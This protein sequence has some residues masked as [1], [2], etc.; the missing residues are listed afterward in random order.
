MSHDNQDTTAI[1]ATPDTVVAETTTV[2]TNGVVRAIAAPAGETT[3]VVAGEPTSANNSE[4][5]AVVS[6]EPPAEPVAEVTPAPAAE[7]AKGP[8]PNIEDVDT[9]TVTKVVRHG[10]G[11]REA[12]K[13][14]GTIRGH[15]AEIHVKDL[16]TDIATIK[17]GDTVQAEVISFE[18]GENHDVTIACSEKLAVARA[19]L[20]ASRGKPLDAV[21]RK[22]V[23]EHNGKPD[24]HLFVTLPGGQGARVFVG[25]LK[26][27]SREERDARLKTFKK[28]DPIKVTLDSFKRHPKFPVL[29]V[30]CKEFN[31]ERMTPRPQANAQ[32]KPAHRQSN[33]R[34]PL[35]GN[36]SGNVDGEK[37]RAIAEAKRAERRQR[38]QQVRNSMK[39]SGGKGGKGK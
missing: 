28:G 19:T 3:P 36:P 16:V 12:F 2:E 9:F 15:K 20:E 34:S 22:D 31:P 37:K 32:P 11:K 17:D 5:A 1:T 29:N 25:H 7:P 18:Y 35:G 13:L 24:A 4:T 23:G 8:V 26:D 38:D 10:K 27:R 14:R 21:V 6:T 39:G 30:E 33:W